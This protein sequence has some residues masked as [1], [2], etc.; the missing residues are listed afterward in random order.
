MQLH[1][2]A[3]SSARRRIA[4]YLPISTAL[5]SNRFE[6]AKEDSE[7]TTSGH[8]NGENKCIEK[9]LMYK[10]RDKALE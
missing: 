4:P 3:S 10:Y 9:I 6:E 7:S 2:S 8:A 1:K 5:S